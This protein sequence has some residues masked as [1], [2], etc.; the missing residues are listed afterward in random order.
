MVS[1]AKMEEGI[2]Y[3]LRVHCTPEGELSSWHLPKGMKSA[4]GFSKF[5]VEE[6]R[7]RVM[8]GRSS[9]SAL[10]LLLVAFLLP[11]VMPGAGSVFV[12][13]S[14]ALCS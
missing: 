5:E 3:Y 2:E 12:P 1:V 11:V 10:T 6:D 8:C 14:D 13:V 7:A 4:L 9:R